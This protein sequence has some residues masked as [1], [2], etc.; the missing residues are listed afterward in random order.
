M[1]EISGSL[2]LIHHMHNDWNVY[3]NIKYK[4]KRNAF[5][6]NPLI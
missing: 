5:P 6:F 2:V 4:D 3:E 1:H